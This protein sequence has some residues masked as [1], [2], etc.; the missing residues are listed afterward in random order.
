MIDLRSDTVTKPTKEMRD[1][2]A[3]AE[4]GDDVY[5]EDPSVN[6]LER[7]AAR[8]FDRES[9]LFVPS[10]TMGN[11]IAIRVLAEPGDEVILDSKSHIYNFEMGTIANF[12]GVIPRT[13]ETDENY[14]P[15]E[16]VEKSV[17]P[18]KYY[19]S[20]TSLISIENTQNVKGGI[21]YPKEKLE[22]L[23]EFA[24]GRNIPVHLDGARIFNA[25]VETGEPVEELTKGID[26][27]MFC[28]SKGLGAP[29]GS[30]LVGD[31]DFIEEARIV[32]KQLGGGMRQVGILAK[33]GLHAL[34]NHIKRLKEDHRNAK[35]LADELKEIEEIEVTPPETNILTVDLTSSELEVSEF[36]N[37]LEEKDV[38]AGSIGP[39]KIRFVT[40]LDIDKKDVERAGEIIKSILQ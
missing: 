24:D 30:M 33:A 4:V 20:Q 39:Q 28:L 2:M 38:K 11:Q 32:R 18:Q 19:I 26:S 8:R 12:S 14:L 34:D 31:E 37:K 1:E 40:H 10:G 21:I 3:H 9:A 36:I 25:S 13:I 29:V 16:K 17:R 27:I 22:E 15:L 7:E 5:G 6:E 35:I 23:V